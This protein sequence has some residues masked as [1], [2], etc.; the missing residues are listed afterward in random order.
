[1]SK[2]ITI[3]P[4]GERFKVQAY[5]QDVVKTATGGLD[6]TRK[7]HVAKGETA[8]FSY[9]KAETVAHQIGRYMFNLGDFI[10]TYVDGLRED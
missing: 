1:M 10:Y 9:V 6:V 7:S 4:V 5:G 3:I 2:P 8:L